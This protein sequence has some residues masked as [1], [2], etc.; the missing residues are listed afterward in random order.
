MEDL[1]A[2]VLVFLN[3]S[4]ESV[5]HGFMEELVGQALRD[6]C[7]VVSGIVA[8][9]GGL[10]V[11][12]GLAFSRGDD[13]INPF[14]GL[15]LSATGYMGLTKVVRSV[16]GFEPYFF[17]VRSDF[18][19]SAFC[20]SNVTEDSLDRI[21]TRLIQVSHDADRKVL[22]TPYAVATLQY[23][24][25]RHTGAFAATPSSHLRLNTNLEDFGEATGVLKRDVL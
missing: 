2:D 5:N 20:L 25:D 13:V 16:P 21:C 1:Q 11:S 23:N 4:L 9:R 6:D 14:R 3:C 17:A 19:R 24:S 22:V 18:A 8:D 10:M 12:C 15:S 7:G